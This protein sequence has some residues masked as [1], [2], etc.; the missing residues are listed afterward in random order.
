MAERVSRP[1]RAA[2]P[3]DM[4]NDEI[5]PGIAT[6]TAELRAHALAGDA[7]DETSFAL[8]RDRVAARALDRGLADVAIAHHDSPLGRILLGATG[9][10]LVRVGLPIESEDAVLDELAARVSPRVLRAP[11]T[12]LDD[13]RR[14][15]DEYFAGRRHEFALALDWCLTASPASPATKGRGRDGRRHPTVGFRHAVLRATAAIPFGR[16]A[17]YAEI[18]A[19]AGSPAAHRATGSALASNPLP[20]VVPCHRVLPSGGGIGQYRGGSEAK[21]RLLALEGAA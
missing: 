13:A 15:L 12:V 9:S 19:Q 11:R 7:F 18:A 4:T 10:G 21:A 2:R 1:R 17:T 3:T 16:T 5:T 8:L 14:Q 6:L 20:I